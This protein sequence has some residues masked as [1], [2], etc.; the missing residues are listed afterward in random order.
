MLGMGE[1]D[2]A[3]ASNVT[4]DQPLTLRLDAHPDLEFTGRVAFIQDTVQQKSW[5]NPA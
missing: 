3:D 2:E 5:R 1:V 4:V